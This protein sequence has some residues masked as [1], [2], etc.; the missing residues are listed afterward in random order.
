[1]DKTREE[2]K[3]G[4]EALT[5]NDL[6][7]TYEALR[8]EFDKGDDVAKVELGLHL[9]IAFEVLTDRGIKIP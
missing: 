1:M 8:V 6:L 7:E 3:E 5:E 4:Y 9:N 2:L